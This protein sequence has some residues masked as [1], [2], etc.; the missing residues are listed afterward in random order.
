M[1]PTAFNFEI[2]RKAFH[3]YGIILPFL[4]L[5]IPKSF[6]VFVLFLVTPCVLY[7]DI[8]RHYNYK[9]KD[10]TNKI[11]SKLMRKKEESGSF[12]LSGASFMI[13]GFFLTSLFFSKELVITSWFILII[14]DSVAS[15]VGIKIGT[16]KISGK[17]IEGA[18]A[19]L[20]SAIFISILCYFYIRYNASF[21]S[22]LI[23]CLV[24][25]MAEL[26]SEKIN[27]DDNLLIPITYCISISLLNLI[28]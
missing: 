7:I 5:C 14:S 21:L 11:F 12:T 9:I 26:Y 22:I 10:L 27:I 25:A 13:S 18:I 23:S 8:S 19:F 17:S 20:S 6:M 3:L 28:M 4:Y 2:K 16:P 1:Q 24:T 15:L